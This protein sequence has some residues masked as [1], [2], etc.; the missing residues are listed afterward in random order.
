MT[1]LLIWRRV[2]T[3][4]KKSE[5]DEFYQHISN[6]Q[7]P[8][9]KH[10]HNKAEGVIE[11]TTLMYIP[12]K[13]PYDLFQPEKVNGLS[14]YVKKIFIMNDCKELLP[15]YLRFI[16]GVVDSED[17]PLNVSR[18][19][20]QQNTVLTKIQKASTK[21][22]L[23]ELQKMADKKPED[24]KKFWN[25]FGTVIKEGFH[26]NWETLDDLKKLVRFTSSKVGQEDIR[27]LG[28]YIKDMPKNSKG[29]ILYYG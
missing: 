19:I 16:K 2:K 3:D 7:E 27:S 9:L 24:Y 5:Y 28:E 25:E 4:I 10:I 22:I 29:N 8:P 17:L 11:Y 20:L 6:D 26:M 13:A 15:T 21:K 18:E 1:N 23:S 12:A 14:L